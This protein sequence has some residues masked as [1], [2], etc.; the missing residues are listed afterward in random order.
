[1]RARKAWSSEPSEW[2]S[3]REIEERNANN[4]VYRLDIIVL[5]SNK[6][7]LADFAFQIV[8]FICTKLVET[9]SK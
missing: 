8:R 4:N 1:M 2:V 3:K 9:Q 7:F 5:W 6:T